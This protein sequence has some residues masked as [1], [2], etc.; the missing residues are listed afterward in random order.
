MSFQKISISVLITCANLEKYLDECVGSVASQTKLPTEVIIVHDGCSNP[1]LYADTTS[2][3]RTNNIGVAHTRDEAVKFSCGDNLLFLDADDCL[4]E[5][6]IQ[7]MINARIVNPDKILYP[8]VL[9]WS[10]WGDGKELNGWH[11]AVDDVNYD[12]LY[13]NN[14]CVV[15]S[16]MPKWVYDKVGGFDPSLR[17]FEDWDMWFKSF[18]L[19]V[20]FQKVPNAYLKYRQRAQS[21]NRLG[22]DIK[23]EVF[24]EIRERYVKKE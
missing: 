22:G 2:F 19:G 17:L 14:P 8:N 10:H 11:E 20:K 5:N 4:S 15:T 9:L 21:R 6:F 12:T 1:R 3:C 16:L 18:M 24:S 23:S 7:E 13:E